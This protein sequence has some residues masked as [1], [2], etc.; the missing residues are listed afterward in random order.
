MARDTIFKVTDNKLGTTVL[1]QAASK[2]KAEKFL[3]TGRFVAEKAS[4]E[5][6]TRAVNEGG[7]ILVEG[8][9]V[10]SSGDVD[11]A[12]TATVIHNGQMLAN[13]AEAKAPLAEKAPEKNLESWPAGHEA[14]V[15]P[16]VEGGLAEAEQAD[17]VVKEQAAGVIASDLHAAE[18]AEKATDA[19]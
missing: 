11:P 18:G 16:S 6:I 17:Q 1:V 19:E 7:K 13:P 8:P 9:H 14:G 12:Q 5:E 15:Q 2:R 3:E 4:P 10:P